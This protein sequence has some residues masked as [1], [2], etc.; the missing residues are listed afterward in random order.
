MVGIASIL[1]RLFHTN[2][3]GSYKAPM[4]AGGRN[5]VNGGKLGVASPLTDR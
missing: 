2:E 1:N 5:G 4:L 3:V